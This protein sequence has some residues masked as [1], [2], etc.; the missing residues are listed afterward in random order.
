MQPCPSFDTLKQLLKEADY[1]AA[2]ELINSWDL[3]VNLQ[4]PPDP[5]RRLGITCMAADVLDYGGQYAQAAHIMHDLGR[6][7][8][9]SLAAVKSGNYLGDDH[10]Y[11]KQQCW[12]VIMRGMCIYRGAIET[13]QKDKPDY[14]NAKRLFQLARD[15]LELIHNDGQVT[16]FGSMA[17]AWYCIGLVERQKQ[18]NRVARR[19][20]TSSVE[21]AAK[22]IERRL[23]NRVA[24]FE[25]N[26]AR[27][28]GLGIGWI[29]YN[30][31]RLAEATAALIMAR[32]QMRG[33]RAKFISAYINVVHASIMLS[34][35]LDVGRVNKAI[36]LLE[37][38]L[39]VFA[40]QN[41]FQHPAY[42]MR[43]QNELAL[44]YLRLATLAPPDDEVGRKRHLHKAE[45]HL[46]SIKD[47]A[48][49]SP[50]LEVRTYWQAL[51]TEA[52]IC[53]VR[54]DYEG[55]L[56]LTKKVKEKGGQMRFTLIDACIG[57][58]E[59]AL[60]LKTYRA[61]IDAFQEALVAGRTSRKIVAVCH[62]HL[63]RTYLADDQPARAL[64]HFKLWE[65]LEPGVE[66]AFI[67]DLGLRV[68]TSMAYILRD[69]VL[70]KD[71][72]KLRSSRGHLNKLRKWLADT[73]FVLADDEVEPAA[74]G[75]GIGAEAFRGWQRL[76]SDDED[77]R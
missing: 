53:R 56:R 59:A 30:G 44:A 28:Y 54:G 36:E 47:A 62:L 22:G 41:G 75:L 72:I 35:S 34:E 57:I 61:A 19:A 55:A 58:G 50:M 23:G 45:V 73:T 49:R 3:R 24:S 60:G 12:A 51:V 71:D 68:R 13:S 8:E 33:I 38:S 74:N 42:A 11:L 26:M 17:R 2:L 66:N 16:C 69:F 46:D 15:V 63:C 27:C 48:K 20:F 5:L 14:E 29:A 65:V 18:E 40:P 67:A 43:A 25:Y 76:G 31:A 7:A 70:S 1:D 21:Y 4:A 6:E 52:R 77:F 32:H 10:S 9:A 39:A 64:E 37:N